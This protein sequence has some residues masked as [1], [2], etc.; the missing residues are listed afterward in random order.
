MS[1]ATSP[2]LRQAT[3]DANAQLR[4]HL[5]QCDL[6]RGRWFSAAML[7]ERVHAIVAPRF[8]TTVALVA[9][10]LVVACGGL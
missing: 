4:H 10:L 8:A 6:A 3:N 5:I 1:T 7:A 2:F 9:L